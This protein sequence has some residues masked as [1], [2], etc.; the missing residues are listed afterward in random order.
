MKMEV[1]VCKHHSARAHTLS[2]RRAAGSLQPAFGGFNH[3]IRI[4]NIRIYSCAVLAIASMCLCAGCGGGKTSSRNT[5]A[6]YEANEDS[7][8]RGAESL[9]RD[10]VEQ[11]EDSVQAYRGLGIALMGQAR[12]QEALEAFDSALSGT[13]DRMPETVK[14]I[15]QYK[16]TCQYRLKAYEDT[17]KTGEELTGMDDRLVSAYFYIGAARLN[18]GNMD[19]AEANFDYA[20]S[21]DPENYKLYLDIYSVYEEA[22]LS[23]IGD[24]YLQ[25][26]LGIAPKTTEDHYNVGR[27]YFYLEEYDE[28]AS[29]LIVPVQEEYE[30][31]LSLMG[32]IYLARKDYDNARATYSQI[33]SRNNE[34]KD[35]YNGL[36]L[37]AIA[38][39]DPDTA[40]DY[41]MKGLSLSGEDGKQAL[42][43][44][45]IVAYE[46]KLDFLTA[47]DKCRTYVE[48]YPTDEDGAKELKFLNTRG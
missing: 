10:A 14:D 27:I 9:F 5:D 41:I 26:A 12:Y 16:I 39:S 4:K 43:F 21:L 36:A 47:R 38:V 42:Y 22:K 30:P 18:L 44:N 1:K 23:G 48:M 32:Q 19:E 33:L 28:A 17:L 15:L 35:A 6:G 7:D 20:V 2:R 25:T 34:S 8:F 29:A 24:E 11:G 3:M 13:D 46:K 40:L 31:A 37:C 45:E